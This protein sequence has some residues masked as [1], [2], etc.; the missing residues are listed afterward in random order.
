M[1]WEV[2]HEHGIFGKE[3]RSRSPGKR[4]LSII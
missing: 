3:K 1:R 4:A 2:I